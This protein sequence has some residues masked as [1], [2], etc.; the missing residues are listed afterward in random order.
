MFT[1]VGDGADVG[2]GPTAKFALDGC[3][4]VSEQ[5]EYFFN[6]GSRR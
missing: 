4:I 2:D 5:L 1:N 6:A 3:Q